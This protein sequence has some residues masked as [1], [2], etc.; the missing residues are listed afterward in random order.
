MKALTQ[1]IDRKDQ[2]RDG[3]YC[4]ACKEHGL[5]ADDMDLVYGW[6][7][8]DAMRLRYH[9]VCCKACTDAHI[10]TEDGVCLP[11]DQAVKDDAGAYWADEDEMMEA[12]FDAQEEASDRRMMAGWRL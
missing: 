2:D 12:Q 5:G 10:V 6:T 1:F 9:A 7:H 3:F 8:S 4:P 11:R